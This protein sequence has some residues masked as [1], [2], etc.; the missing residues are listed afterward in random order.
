LGVAPAVSGLAAL[1]ISDVSGAPAA[2]LAVGAGAFAVIGVLEDT[3]GV[4]PAIRLVLQAAV[5]AVTLPWLLNGFTSSAAWLVIAAIAIVGWLV[6]F[7]NA[8][9]FMDGINGISVA[10]AA[11][12]GAAFAIVGSAEHLHVLTVGGLILAAVAVGF[13]PVN[14][15]TALGFMGDAG[16]YFLGGWIAL[17]T[18]IALR[19]RVP[20]EAVFGSSM[21]YLADT[22]TTLLRRARHGEVWWQ[23]HRSHSYQRLVIAGWRHETTTAFVA[24][25][26]LLCAA[27]GSLTV[28]AS[29]A[30][31]AVADAGIAIVTI[32]YL[33]A[34]R[35]VKP[36]TVYP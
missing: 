10:D 7:V 1:A 8:F 28:D 9:N 5:A 3:R 15:P 11:V 24:G 35:L 23:P 36:V 21:I 2:A 22:S 4:P 18:V 17:L 19:L 20:A 13:A 12:A 32:G 34:P 29:T 25:L 27:F 31:R 33:A 26:S 6:G 14:F 16:S 30:L